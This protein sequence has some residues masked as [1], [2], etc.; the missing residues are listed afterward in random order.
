M[1]TCKQRQS[2]LSCLIYL[3][4][5]GCL[6]L[7]PLGPCLFVHEF[8]QFARIIGLCQMP[9]SYRSLENKTRHALFQKFRRKMASELGCLSCKQL[10]KAH[11]T[12]PYIRLSQKSTL[13]SCIF[14]LCFRRIMGRI[15]VYLEL[16]LRSVGTVCCCNGIA[17]GTL[18]GEILSP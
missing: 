11:L 15:P 3:S 16:L 1:C 10:S 8:C 5:N 9:E 17:F 4:R 14:I 13:S 2:Q 18:K 7:Y 12:Q 6:L